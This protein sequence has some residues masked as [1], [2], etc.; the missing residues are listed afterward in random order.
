VA[1]GDPHHIGLGRARQPMT[2]KSGPRM[3]ILRLFS[4]FFG[5]SRTW[6]DGRPLLPLLSDIR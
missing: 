2:T 6:M 1:L 4:R 3:S 5:E